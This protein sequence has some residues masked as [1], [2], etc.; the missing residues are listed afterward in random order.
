L[1][2]A[3]KLKDSLLVMLDPERL[4]PA[5]LDPARLDPARLD[6]ARPGS[7]PRPDRAGPTA[8]PAA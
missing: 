2:G 6:P 7:A 3:Y 8:A 1:A 5:R 4:D